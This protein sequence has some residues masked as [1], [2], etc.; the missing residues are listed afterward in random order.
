MA[1]GPGSDNEKVGLEAS[2]TP[3]P[4]SS[5]GGAGFG[6]EPPDLFW[7]GLAFPRLLCCCFFFLVAGAREV[8]ALDDRC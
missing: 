7:C 2:G 8:G 5:G 4:V 3:W 1:A 6:V